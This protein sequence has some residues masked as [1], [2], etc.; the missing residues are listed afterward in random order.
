M[1]RVFTYHLPAHFRAPPARSAISVFQRALSRRGS[2]CFALVCLASPA[3]ADEIW[4]APTYQ[5]DL[6]GTGIASNGLWPVSAV[7]ASRLAWAVPNDLQAFQ[8]AKLVLIPHAPGGA[9]NANLVTSSCAGPFVH[10]FVGVANQLL[11]VDISAEVGARVGVPGQPISRCSPTQR[12]RRRP[13]TSSGCGSR[14]K[15]QRSP[16]RRDRLVRKDRKAKQAQ[17]V[18]RAR[19]GQGPSWV[20]AYQV[21]AF[22]QTFAFIPGQELFHVVNCGPQR[23]VLNGGFRLGLQQAPKT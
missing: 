20:P 21:V 3:S 11:E 10:A 23:L 13:I 18:Q 8:H 22:Q 6:G 9:A 15:G 17:L 5:A 4:V 1:T 12:P 14:M 19:L 2:I 7:G 16:A